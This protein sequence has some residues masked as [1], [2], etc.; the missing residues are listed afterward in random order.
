MGSDPTGAELFFQKW[1]RG[2]YRYLM[3]M[4]L[5]MSVNM[6]SLLAVVVRR[7]RVEN[8]GEKGHVLNVTS[9]DK[10]WT[11]CMGVATLTMIEEEV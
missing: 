7:L 10:I 6:I 8:G 11:W 4:V 9:L 2:G 3:F 1:K 5:V